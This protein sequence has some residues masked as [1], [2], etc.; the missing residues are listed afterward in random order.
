MVGTIIALVI[1]Y[2]FGIVSALAV[3]LAVARR[4]RR[5]GENSWHTALAAA[6]VLWL[7]VSIAAVTVVPPEGRAQWIGLLF[8]AHLLAGAVG[9]WIARRVFSQSTEKGSA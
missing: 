7:L 9:T 4:D 3:G 8:I 2:A 1:A 5:R 6:L